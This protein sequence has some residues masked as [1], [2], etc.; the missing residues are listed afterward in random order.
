MKTITFYN[1]LK[2]YFLLCFVV[3]FV[4]QIVQ[5]QTAPNVLWAKSYGGEKDELPKEIVTDASDNIY[6]TGSFREETD[7]QGIILTTEKPTASF[8]LKTDSSGNVLWVKKTGDIN[9]VTNYT[10]ITI[11][12]SGYIYAMGTFWG[13][14]TFG[15]ITLDAGYFNNIYVVKLNSLGGVLWATQFG[16]IQDFVFVKST[17][18]A[19]DSQGNIYTTGIFLGDSITFGNITLNHTS[20]NETDNVFVVKQDS[21]GNV[22]WAKNFNQSN[23][24]SVE[25][26]IID[27]LDNVY[28]V[29]NFMGTLELGE[30]IFT[31]LD[32]END[33]FL[34]KLDP[35]GEVIWAKQF[36]ITSSVSQD[37]SVRDVAIDEIGNIYL[38]GRFHGTLQVETNT[39]TTS[40]LYVKNMFVV[41]TDNLGNPLWAKEFGGNS[42]VFGSSIITDVSNNVY[43]TGDLWDDT[44]FDSVFLPYC[45]ASNTC[46][47]LLK[48]ND[49][50]T[51]EWVEGYGGFTSSTSIRNITKDANENLLVL[52]IFDS[53]SVF[54]DIALASAGGRDMFILQ[55]SENLSIKE[56][57]TSNWSA[58][59]N[60][61]NDFITLDFS[62]YNDT[63]LSVEVFNMLGQKIK[64]FENVGVSE[65]IDLSQ[66]TSGIYLLKI[67]YNETIQTIKIKKL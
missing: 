25:K 28:I 36:E 49:L 29:G 66:L 40:T 57:K 62:D 18:I 7:F 8:V 19:A 6:I 65:K 3:L 22:L 60:P 24:A 5:S 58:Y 37:S 61:T 33:V 16:N 20:E 46:P 47:F 11:D 48:I 50:G 53:V 15:D 27:A 30:Y 39:L 56:N 41:K 45:G 12:N 35:L 4:T 17:S 14:A 31:N 34:A 59:P 51:I 23:Y 13:V 32:M 1:Q 21:S 63:E 64:F 2:N 55:L 43:I 9:G 42:Q 44:W 38:T 54:G 52:G 26:V 10:G 67:N